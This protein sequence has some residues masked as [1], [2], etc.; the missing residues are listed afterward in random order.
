MPTPTLKDEEKKA[1]LQR[2]RS[3][4]LKA[5]KVEAQNNL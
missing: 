2:S 1:L 5:G 3:K 4:K